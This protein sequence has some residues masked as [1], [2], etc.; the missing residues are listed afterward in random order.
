MAEGWQKVV[1]VLRWDDPKLSTLAVS[2]LTSFFYL[3]AVQ[4]YSLVGL[5]SWVLLVH[6][7]VL[8]ALQTLY[9]NK[10]PDDDYEFV[11]RELLEDLITYGYNSANSMIKA[12]LSPRS[13]EK[14]IQLLLGLVLFSFVSQL[15]STEGFLWTLAVLSFVATPLYKMKSEEINSAL[16]IANQQWTTIK[17]QAIDKIPKSSSA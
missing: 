11:S 15:F 8:Y 2:C 5:V 6:L 7:V 10:F 17:N 14:F 13:T 12:F 4:G 9:P 3:L 16:E 1:S